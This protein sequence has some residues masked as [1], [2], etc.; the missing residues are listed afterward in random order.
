MVILEHG[1]KGT[2]LALYG[3]NRDLKSANG[4]IWRH[5]A[6]NSAIYVAPYGAKWRYLLAP[7]APTISAAI[8][9]K[10]HMA[11]LAPFLAQWRHFGAILALM[12]PLALK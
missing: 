8:F 4:A 5:V 12:A 7:L 9:Q 2:I 1:K 3:A 11:P 10:Q 6:V